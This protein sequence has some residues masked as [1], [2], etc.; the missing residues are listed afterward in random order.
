LI[1]KEKRLMD[2]IDCHN[3]AT[4][5]FLS[6]EQLIDSAMVEGR[7]DRSLPFIKKQGARA[8]YPAASNLDE[9]DRKI[10]EIGNYYK[11]SY[12]QV[13]AEKSPSINKAIE[14]LKNIARL[15]TFPDMKVSWDSYEN[16]LGHQTSLGCLRCHGKLVDSKSEQTGKTIDVSCDLC[17]YLT[18]SQ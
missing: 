14:E 4:H 8:L 15:T 3:R 13:Y 1:E 9:A 2:C 10:E 17:H 5:I 12:P 6:P 18:K 16:N 11:N 7:I